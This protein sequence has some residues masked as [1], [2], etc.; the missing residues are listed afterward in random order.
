MD[1]LP[2]P[3]DPENVRDAWNVFLFGDLHR[4]FHGEDV[5]LLDGP[6]SMAS[7]QRHFAELAGEWMLKK[8]VQRADGPTA[9][10]FCDLARY[11]AAFHKKLVFLFTPRLVVEAHETRARAALALRPTIKK[12]RVDKWRQRQ[13][14]PAWIRAYRDLVRL[15]L[16]ARKN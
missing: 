13:G 9:Q 1:A 3:D 6:F 15:T 5:S 12:K 2:R 10:D 14:K 7:I 11:T 16:N 8:A 4:A